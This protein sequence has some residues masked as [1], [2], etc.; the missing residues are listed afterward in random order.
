MKKLGR[1]F[2]AALLLFALTAVTLADGQMDVPLTTPTPSATY[3]GQTDTPSAT[4][5]SAAVTS[6][7]NTTDTTATEAGLLLFQAFSS[8]L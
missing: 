5:S 7:T 3:Q 8:V 4:N 2:A 6:Q 1:S